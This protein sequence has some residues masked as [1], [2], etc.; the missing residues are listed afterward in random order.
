M[1]SLSPTG[2]LFNSFNTKHEPP[3]PMELDPDFLRTLNL[4]QRPST[5]SLE[6]DL[7]TDTTMI[8]N[9]QMNEVFQDISSVINEPTEQ[10]PSDCVDNTDVEQ[11]VKEIFDSDISSIESPL[12]NESVDLSWII[13]ET[14]GADALAQEDAGAAPAE[15]LADDLNLD[16]DLLSQ[17]ENM[18]E[19]SFD[20]CL[21]VGLSD[22]STELPVPASVQL[23]PPSPSADE[24][25]SV[26]A[27]D[28]QYTQ[29]ACI[30]VKAHETK[31][32]AIRR[33]KNNAAS[34]VCR[35]QRKTRLTTNTQRIAE[36]T[37]SNG[38]LTEQIRSIESVV[39]LLKENLVRAT[40]QK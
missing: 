12:P 30:K 25:T 7:D 37:A 8:D 24:T 20:D 16:Y 32:E 38:A 14:L 15:M 35:R 31:K 18:N 29:L 22:Q 34:R 19:Q 11:L 10:S 3:D 39:L 36:L 13:N 2:G 28:H 17:L 23:M 27:L 6:S 1:R 40:C 9:W 5:D 26:I 4:P 33:V 21:A